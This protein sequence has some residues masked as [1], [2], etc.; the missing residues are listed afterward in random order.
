MRFTQI[1]TIFIILFTIICSPSFLSIV[2]PTNNKQMHISHCV[3]N[4]V[5]FKLFCTPKLVRKYFRRFDMKFYF[6]ET[7]NVEKGNV[8]IHIV[9]Y[10]KRS[11]IF[12]VFRFLFKEEFE[13]IST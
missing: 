8:L 5:T 6:R 10:Q 13:K 11:N 1:H 2:M 3:H 9:L 12:I 4:K 7:A